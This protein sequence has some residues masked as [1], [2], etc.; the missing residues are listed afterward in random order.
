MIGAAD[1]GSTS[2]EHLILESDIFVFCKFCK[3][4]SC[5]Q[6]QRCQPAMR[7]SSNGRWA[8]Y[9]ADLTGSPTAN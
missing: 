9:Q 1:P 6:H 4:M 5:N 3:P 8:A 2:A 7:A